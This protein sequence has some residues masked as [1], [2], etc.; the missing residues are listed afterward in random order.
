[1]RY[2]LMRKDPTRKEEFLRLRQT[3]RTEMLDTEAEGK[4]SGRAGK[5]FGRILWQGVRAAWRCGRPI[6]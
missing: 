4:P 3:L 1:M 6:P 2:K 5:F